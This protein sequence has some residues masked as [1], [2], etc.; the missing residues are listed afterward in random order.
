MLT[1]TLINALFVPSTA[2]AAILQEIVSPATTLTTSESSTQ[3]L[4]DA[5]LLLG[6]SKVESPLLQSVHLRVL[7]AL[8]SA[9]V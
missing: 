9:F 5:F 7:H 8:L 3:P 2:S 1:P 4:K 6:T